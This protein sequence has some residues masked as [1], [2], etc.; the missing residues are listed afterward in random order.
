MKKSSHMLLAKLAVLQSDY[1]KKKSV[2]DDKS[3]QSTKQ[4]SS[5]R[6]PVRPVSLCDDRNCQSAKCVHIEKPVMPQPSYKMRSHKK[7]QVKSE[8]TQYY[9]LWSILKTACKQI[10]TQTEVARINAHTGLPTHDHF[11]CQQAMCEHSTS[12]SCYPSETIKVS[13]VS[14]NYKIQSNHSD[15]RSSKMQSLQKKSVNPGKMQSDH[16]QAAQAELQRK[17]QVNTRLQAQTSK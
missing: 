4:H 5:E 13:P 16:M 17:S 6:C 1:K 15:S 9:P 3:C 11:V 14:Q 12:K 10:G 2:C 7:C 8:G